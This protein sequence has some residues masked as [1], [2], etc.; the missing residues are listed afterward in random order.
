M[1]PVLY[2]RRVHAT[3]P[4]ASIARACLALYNGITEALRAL[5]TVPSTER[6]GIQFG[7][8]AQPPNLGEAWEIRF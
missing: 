1:F 4:S 8:I 3:K 7:G 6:G 5:L 2:V